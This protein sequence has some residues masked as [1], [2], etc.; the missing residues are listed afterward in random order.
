M[1]RKLAALMAVVT[2]LLCGS[3]VFG[4][5][6][7]ASIVGRVSDGSGAVIPNA[8][9]T[10]TNADTSITYKTKTTQSGDYLITTLPPGPYRLEAEVQGFRKHV[11]DSI[12]LNIGE[13][14]A[15]DIT[16][17]PGEV[18]SSITVSGDATQLEVSTASRGETITGKTL[19]DLPLNGRNAFA[20]AGLAPGVNITSRGQAST[21]LRTTANNGISSLSLSGSLPRQN[22]AL[23]DGVPNTG[24]DGLIQ[25]VPSVDAT[26]EFKVQTNS[27]DA[28][29][30]RFTGGVINAMIKSGTNDFH[31]AAFEF[32]RNS[33]FNARDP[34]AA[35]IPQ[36]GYNLYGFS[37]GAPVW[38]PK[39][40]K[41]RNRTFWFFNVEGSREG[42]PRAFIST[43]PTQEQLA[44]NFSQTRVR[45][46]ATVLPVTIYD[47]ATTR[48][49]GGTFV[50]DPFPGNVIPQNRFDP[51]AR[52]V[53]KLFPAPNTT[54]DTVTGANNFALSF[55]DTTGD[56]GYVGKLDHRF[57]DNHSMFFRY[58]MR[59]W[60]VTRAGSF[61][62]PLTGDRETRDAP[63]IALDDTITITPTTILNVRYG[64]SR[65][66][67]QSQAD[68]FGTDMTSIGF[69]ASYARL[70]S[71]QAIPQLSISGYT[72]ISGATKFNK[73]AED[74]HTLRGALTKILGSHTLKL[75][76][77]GRLM[78]SNSGS[79]G[80]G[81]A[82]S[83]NFDSAF[84]R[85]P[86]PQVAAVQAGQSLASF[87]LGLG[88]GGSVTNNATT[89]DSQTY[90]GFYGQDDIRLS[91]KLTVNLGLRLEW[92]GP[93]TER[94]NRLNRGFDTTTATSISARAQQ[95][96]AASPISEIPAAS[97]KAVGGLLFAGVGG[98]PEG[99]ADILRNI[100]PRVG[101][102]Y[103]ITPRT[104]LRGGYGL[105]YG[106]STLSGE[107]RNGFSVSTPFV[108][109]IDGSLT[110]VNTLSN[111]FPL[112]LIAPAGAAD[113]LLTLVGQGVSF[114]D[115]N[116]RQPRSHQYQAGIQREL[117]FQMLADVAYA[118]ARTSDLSLDRQINAVPA[119]VR[120]AAEQT[121]RDTG[122]NILNDQVNNPFFGLISGGSLNAARTTRGQL[123]RPYPQFT[124]VV[125]GA[126]P[127]GSIQYDSLQA[128]VSKRM[129]AGLT[130]LV[131]FTW[132]KQMENLR[133]LNDQ[134]AAPVHEIGEF[135]YRRRLTAS[136]TY[137]LPIRG[138]LIGG[139]SLNAIY[140]YQG[141]IP[142][143]VT[144]ARSLGKSAKLD[145]PTVGKWFDT[146]AFR[147]IMT[148]EQ[149]VTSRLPD[150]RSGVK[151]NWD[152]SMFKNTNITEHIRVQFR[153]ES[154]NTMNTPE[155]SSPGGA[156]GTGNFGVVT[157]TNTFARQLQFGLKLLW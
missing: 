88:S 85:G 139:W 116:R 9:I 84:T 105:F 148:L 39:L 73:S 132:M 75:G 107:A 38:L 129:T 69:P 141:G 131:A 136:A 52:S 71:V 58:S 5:E 19:V 151:N 155:W 117:P 21:F 76:A 93:Y 90:Y 56:D 15:I 29:Y 121:F 59:S 110:P 133:F 26:Q 137:Q 16:L 35:T 1:S 11:R 83:F 20:L 104:V 43:V 8:Q 33:A 109:T 60:Y 113:G 24:T 94:Y 25:F 96:Y 37:A 6:F 114:T 77:E 68:V 10:V 14:P 102:A 152:I 149:L 31:G 100:A 2:L 145:E 62:G 157:S 72:G 4:Q 44:G 86:N 23:L 57:S 18:T 154:F 30:G 63:G 13:R 135:D 146:S 150:V 91:R 119:A 122:R 125:S 95:A 51:V 55:K 46:G 118:G 142:V 22:E 103:Q 41:G 17:E 40:Y 112:G 66:L 89:A 108:G 147:Q 92:E 50:R 98:Q 48:Q 32:L 79:L 126:S 87:L 130:A 27:F 140:T 115:P 156:F 47:P 80:A 78:R 138:R 61:R 36:F 28:E 54:G 111:P 42:V 7:R 34:F 106:A 143:A 53:V 81:A 67:V 99:I 127:L 3:L 49:V 134:D 123:V 74:S 97:F 101:A 45:S 124:S 120:D 12:T 153:V 82:G 64:F 128:K 65:F 144:G 70:L